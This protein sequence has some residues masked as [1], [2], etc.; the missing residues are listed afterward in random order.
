LNL[1]KVPQKHLILVLGALGA[2]DDEIDPR[3]A[4][5]LRA[6]PRGLA[7]DAANSPCTD[8]PDAAD[9]AMRAANGPASDSEA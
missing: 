9:G 7:D 8:A 1:V 2:A 5:S 4:R 6:G 3:A